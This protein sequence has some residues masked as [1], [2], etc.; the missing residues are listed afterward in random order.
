MTIGKH[1]KIL[2]ITNQKQIK[3]T[4]RY[5]LTPVRMA[6]MKKTKNVILFGACHHPWKQV[7]GVVGRQPGLGPLTKSQAPQAGQGAVKPPTTETNGAVR[8]NSF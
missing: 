4:V 8:E 6:I 3:T 2:N 7:K 5:H 1:E